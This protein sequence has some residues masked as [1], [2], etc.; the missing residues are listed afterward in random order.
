MQG[1]ATKYII[2]ILL[3]TDHSQKAREG[4][5]NFVPTPVFPPVCENP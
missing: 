5:Q 1:I 4:A 3:G 2:N